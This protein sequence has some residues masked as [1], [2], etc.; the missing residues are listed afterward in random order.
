MLAAIVLIIT[1]FEEASNL[2]P[3][4]SGVVLAPIVVSGVTWIL[5]LLYERHITKDTKNAIPVEPIRVWHFKEPVFPWRFCQS[6]VIVSVIAFVTLIIGA[7]VSILTNT[8]L[9]TLSF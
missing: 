2:S 6:R 3:W 1:G 5:F 9:G 4:T 8:C 7:P